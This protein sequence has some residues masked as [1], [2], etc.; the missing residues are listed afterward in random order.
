MVYVN[1]RGD[2]VKNIIRVWRYHLAGYKVIYFV[3]QNTIKRRL[4][5]HQMKNKLNYFVP[6]SPKHHPQ[7]F[8]ASSAGAPNNIKTKAINYLLPSPFGE[9]AGV[10]LTPSCHP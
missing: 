10:R 3:P 6:Y 2:R 1:H 7:P 4:K 9:G 8:K 5:H